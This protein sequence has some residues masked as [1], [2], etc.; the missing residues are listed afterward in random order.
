MPTRR[1]T[2]RL[3]G[4]H[5]VDGWERADLGGLRGSAAAIRDKGM[6]E[7]R[8]KR[9]MRAALG[10]HDTPKSLRKTANR[11]TDLPFYL[12]KS[13]K[14]MDLSESMGLLEDECFSVGW[15]IL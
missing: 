14:D 4:P 15:N 2:C 8:A 5:G 9:A 1:E 6:G 10:E 13:D 11:V 3:R 7:R 12:R